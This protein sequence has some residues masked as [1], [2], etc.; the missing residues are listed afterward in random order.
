[1]SLA[2][3]IRFTQRRSF[4]SSLFGATFFGTIITVAASSILPCPVGADGQRRYA[5]ADTFPSGQPPLPP[6]KQVAN[7]RSAPRTLVRLSLNLLTQC[8]LVYGGPWYSMYCC[9]VLVGANG[10]NIHMGGH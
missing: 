9:D 8:V 3:A 1:M 7:K 10:S 2:R 4:I 5:D 6:S